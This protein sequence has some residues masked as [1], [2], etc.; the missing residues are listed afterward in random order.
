MDIS[1]IKDIAGVK[2]Y[3][4]KLTEAIKND[5][6]KIRAVIENDLLYLA[7]FVLGYHDLDYLHFDIC[8]EADKNRID[9]MWLLPR[10]HLKST[11]LT[12]S[13]TI[14]R[15]LRNPSETHLIAN[16]TLDNARR[17]LSE[18]KQHLQGNSTLRYLYPFICKP[19]KWDETQIVLP[20]KAIV[21]EATITAAG[22]GQAFASQHYDSITFDDL[23]NEKNTENFEQIEKVI[24]WFKQIYPLLKP[25]GK[26]TVIGTRW[27]LSDLYSYIQ[28]EYKQ[29]FWVYVRKVIED[30][31]FIYPKKFNQERVDKLKRTMKLFLYS[32]QYENNPVATED[33]LFKEEYFSDK[34][35]K[36]DITY[37]QGFRKFIIV[38]PASTKKKN[39]DYTAMICLGID[40]DRTRYVV[41][42]RRD[43][44]TPQEQID[45]IFQMVERN[46]VSIV[47]IE[48]FGFQSYLKFNLEK[49]MQRRD[50][51]SPEE[52]KWQGIKKTFFT[53]IELSPKGRSKEDRI[54]ALEPI[55]RSKTLR[56]IDRY[57]YIS[58]YDKEVHDGA[59]QL[60]NELLH[61]TMQGN[62]SG[63]D[64]MADC[65]SYCCDL[66][67]FMVPDMNN[68]SMV[69]LRRQYEEELHSVNKSR[70]A[71]LEDRLR[72]DYDN[73]RLSTLEEQV[74]V[75]GY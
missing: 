10:E 69:S 32:C 65:L 48:S 64:D 71:E 4:L 29:D 36:E 74:S 6:D 62:K 7:F 61:Q 63:H 34:F 58:V 59:E 12:I 25:N 47:G 42:A 45:A 15:V 1:T 43:K 11:I 73:I 51:L 3:Y 9:E 19:L 57:E 26:R 52:K 24:R 31:R 14:Q 18:I 27:D 54:S 35:T 56:L 2:E 60:V 50:K 46:D 13:R 37:K 75:T 72:I 16:A 68:Y 17:F 39:S 49:E 67:P 5:D 70:L 44:Y 40:T 21:K 55:L 20:R 38:D 33:Q 53:I 28:K 23:L 66:D 41:E 22:V 8:R 30:G